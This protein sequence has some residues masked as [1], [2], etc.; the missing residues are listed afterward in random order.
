MRDLFA[1][2]WN[3]FWHVALGTTRSPELAALF[4]VY[5]V[6]TDWGKENFVVDM[7]EFIL[8]WGISKL[9]LRQ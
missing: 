3:S 5:Q 9:L 1:D 6:E 7:S 4:T 8:G 2:G